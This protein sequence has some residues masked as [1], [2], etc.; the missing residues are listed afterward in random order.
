MPQPSGYSDRP[1]SPASARVPSRGV[2]GRVAAVVAVGALGIVV[3]LGLADE[4]KAQ[5]RGTPVALHAPTATPTATPREAPTGA[6]VPASADATVP[7]A[8]CTDAAPTSGTP[9][10]DVAGALAGDGGN[11][12]RPLGAIDTVPNEDRLDFL[13][14]LPGC[15]RDAHWIDP[16]N[17][18]LGSGIWT[19]GRPFHVREGFVT[20]GVEPLG[21]GFDVV[22]YVTRL[23][24]DRDEPTYRYTSDYVLQGATD[25]CGPGYRTQSA[26]EPCEW[27]VHDFPDGLLEGRFA[28]W[29]FWEA[30]CRAWVDLGFAYSCAEPD[31]VVSLFASGFDAPYGQSGPDYVAPSVP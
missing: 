17:P 1:E 12:P 26:P 20:N 27:F 24:T 10:P 6:M 13:F 4:G 21:E 29:A 25:R 14:E 18:R 9:L 5:P 8:G 22:L 2:P 16:D 28:I 11:G 19:A 15:F 31:G 30:P 7:P 23:E 3:A